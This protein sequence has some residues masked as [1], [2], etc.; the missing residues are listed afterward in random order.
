MFVQS[1]ASVPWASSL[2]FSATYKHPTPPLPRPR[3]ASVQVDFEPQL[4]L[5]PFMALRPK[6]PHIYDLYGVLVH[7]GHSMHSGHYFCFVKAANGHWFLC[8]DNHVA[9]V[10]ER[11]VLAQKAYI[12]FYIKQQ[13][14][15]RPP[16][17]PSSPGNDSKSPA[18]AAPTPAELPQQATE[19]VRKAFD[20]L[21]PPIAKAKEASQPQQQEQ[22]QEQ[23]QEQEQHLVAVAAAAPA[24]ATK[25]RVLEGPEGPA[26]A[27]HAEVA[28]ERPKAKKHKAGTVPKFAGRTGG[29]GQV[30]SEE[31]DYQPPH[32]AR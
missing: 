3:M 4:D 31:A 7:V 14:T 26:A 18:A 1:H 2:S 16:P 8:D 6:E 29:D 24:P 11:N 28:L 15:A 25:K 13:A 5:S 17:L 23:E 19:A 30:L 32:P 10:G 20:R 21:R 27:Q 22:R 12:L 9:S